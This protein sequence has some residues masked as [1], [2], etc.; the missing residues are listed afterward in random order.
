M[1]LRN[2][3]L[4]PITRRYSLEYR[5]QSFQGLMIQPADGDSLSHSS[6]SK[7]DGIRY[8]KSKPINPMA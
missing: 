6:V 5:I 7:T 1:L 2:V 3:V 8:C 4:L